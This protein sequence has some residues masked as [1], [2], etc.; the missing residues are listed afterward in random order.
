MN[1]PDRL[2]ESLRELAARPAQGLPPALGESLKDEFRRHHARRRRMR[3]A[4]LLAAAL[5]IAAALAPVAARLHRS[6]ATPPAASLRAAGQGQS[7]TALSQD[8]A[9]GQASSEYVALPGYDPDIPVG[10]VRVVRLQV[11]GRDL[12]L[13]GLPVAQ[14][15]AEQQFVADVLVAQDGTPYALRLVDQ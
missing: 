7:G 6:A 10:S 13:V 8:A 5:V 14:D 1:E 9:V 3:T 15:A 2:F 4:G 12:T 11:S